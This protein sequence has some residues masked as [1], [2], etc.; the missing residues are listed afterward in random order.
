MEYR[1]LIQLFD[2]HAN[3]HPERE[4]FVLYDLN[5][6]YSYTF[7]KMQQESLYLAASFLHIGWKRGQRVVLMI[8]SRIEFLLCYMALLRIG[9][10]AILLP[11]SGKPIEEVISVISRYDCH[12]IILC[13]GIE[14]CFDDQLMGFLKSRKEKNKIVLIDS[15]KTD[16]F[17]GEEYSNF[18]DLLKSGEK[19]DVNLVLKEQEQVQLDDV[20][21]VVFTSGST[22][23]PKAVQYTHHSIVN[24]SLLTAEFGYCL[25][26]D[27]ERKLPG[28]CRIFNDRPFYWAGCLFGGLNSVLCLGSTLV[29]APAIKTVKEC[30]LDFLL[31]LLENER[32]TNAL[33]MAYI[34]VDIVNHSEAKNYDL[35]HLEAILSGGQPLSIQVL[36]KLGSILPKC[37]VIYGYGLSELMPLAAELVSLENTADD[38]QGMDLVPPIEMKITDGDQ[39]LV[40]VGQVGEVCARSP[41]SFLEYLDDAQATAKAKS[42]TGW[43]HYWRHGDS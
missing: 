36:N 41:C 42:K 23:E 43:V 3:T 12:G 30:D 25:Q 1:T 33:F 26:V 11:S 24:G 37:K 16:A 34:V 40:P 4:A 21:V 13:L 19:V 20:A 9:V 39:N 27:R 2:V 17:V 15:E 28:E 7:E 10:N 8:P 14:K 6:R 35:S 5:Q 32:C 38:Y 31:R 18:R 22:G 29:A